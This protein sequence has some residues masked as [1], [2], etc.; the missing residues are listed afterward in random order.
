MMEDDVLTAPLPIATGPDWGVPQGIGLGV[1]VDENKVRKYHQL[2]AERGQFLP[3]QAT[4]FER[5]D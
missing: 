5:Q 1:E 4:M 2:Y 3:Y